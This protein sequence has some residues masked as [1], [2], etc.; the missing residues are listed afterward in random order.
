MTALAF[1][2]LDPLNDADR[3]EWVEGLGEPLYEWRA[4]RASA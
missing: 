2:R 4:S 1:R 3:R